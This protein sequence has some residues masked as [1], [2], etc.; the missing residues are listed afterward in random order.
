MSNMVDDSTETGGCI[1][2]GK[3]QIEP[4]DDTYLML[5]GAFM[6][7]TELGQVVFK[8]D[9]D[10]IVTVLQLADGSMALV[11][12]SQAPSPTKYA[13]AKCVH[14]LASDTGGEDV[15]P[16]EYDPSHTEWNL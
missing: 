1:L 12:P 13:E 16:D 6:D 11:A 10:S 5:R 3:P 9:P 2:C 7:S 14:L 4:L 15:D 8:L